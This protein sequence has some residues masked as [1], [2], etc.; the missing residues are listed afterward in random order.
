MSECPACAMLADHVAIIIPFTET[1][2]ILVQHR[3]PNPRCPSPA[4]AEPVRDLNGIT[5]R[6]DAALARV[7][8]KPRPTIAATIAPQG[9][10]R[11]PKIA[12]APPTRHAA[13]GLPPVIQPAPAVANLQPPVVQ[14]VQDSPA[15]LV[16]VRATADIPPFVDMHGQTQQLKAGDLASLPKGAAELLVRRGK[17]A[18]VE[19]TA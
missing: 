10:L 3:C 1:G 2:Q 5:Q 8:A 14:A 19:A 13:P 16:I 11:L 15:P 4:F 9:E 7:A 18:M 6:I 12:A 17:A